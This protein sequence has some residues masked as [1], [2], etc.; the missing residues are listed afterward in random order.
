M[1]SARTSTGNHIDAEIVHDAGDWTAFEPVDDAIE[2]AIRA[3]ASLTEIPV[4]LPSV[5]IALSNDANVKALNATYR[6]KNYPTNVL[7]FP[8]SVQGTLGDIVLAA[9]T[10]LREAREQEISPQHHLQ[11]LIIHGILHLLGYDHET[12]DQAEIMESLEIRILSQL[13]ISNPYTEPL[14]NGMVPAIKD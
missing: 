1:T 4:Q 3:A 14:D 2:L 11:H 13:G 5:C 8:S 7:S 9:E 12:A 10:V 6:G